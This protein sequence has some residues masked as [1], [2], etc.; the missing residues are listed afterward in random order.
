MKIKDVDVQRKGIVT[1]VRLVPAVHKYLCGTF[2]IVTRLNFYS[3]FAM[4]ETF[5][6]RKK[7][8]FLYGSVLTVDIPRP[9]RASVS[10][11]KDS[12]PET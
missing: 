10:S 1:S 9:V 2:P 5:D 4:A 6:H 3:W 8:S 12:S 11:L 7:K